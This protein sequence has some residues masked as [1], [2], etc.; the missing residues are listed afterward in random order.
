MKLP[1]RKRYP[2]ELVI[3]NE[4]YRV[5]FVTKISGDCQVMGNCNPTTRVIQIKNNQ[6]AG[7][8]FATLI[9]ELLHAIEFEYDLDIPHK[10]V[11]ALEKALADLF[12][13]NF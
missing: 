11:Y 5:R 12:L 4:V 8:T 1:T 13:Q 7:E 9:H 10:H 6:S 3:N 2:Q